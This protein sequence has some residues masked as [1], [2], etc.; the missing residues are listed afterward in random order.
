MRTI[1]LPYLQYIVKQK[2]PSKN[3]R[4]PKYNS[5]VKS[6]LEQAKEALSISGD[7]ENYL[8]FYWFVKKNMGDKYRVPFDD[9]KVFR[10]KHFKF[11]NISSN[12]F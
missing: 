3:I 7:F 12:S 1:K 8:Q 4:F 5:F 9:S 6:C 2:Q 11:Q 10:Q